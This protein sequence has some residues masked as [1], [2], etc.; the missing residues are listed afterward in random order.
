[1]ATPSNEAF[2]LLVLKNGWEVW[3]WECEND[4]ATTTEKILMHPMYCLQ[5]KAV[6]DKLKDTEVGVKMELLYTTN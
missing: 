1:L 3:K 5:T 4:Q 6:E 2:C